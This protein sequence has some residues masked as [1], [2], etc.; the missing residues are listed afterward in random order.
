M[1]K[2]VS[3]PIDIEVATTTRPKPQRALRFRPLLSILCCIV[4]VQSLRL[5][6]FHNAFLQ[7][8]DTRARVISIHP[9]HR[10]ELQAICKSIR[11]PAGPPHSFSTAARTENDRFVPGT[12]PVL[13]RNA[14]IWTGSGNGTEIVHGDVLLDRGLVVAIGDIPPSLLDRVRQSSGS[15]LRVEDVGGAWVTPGLVDLHSHLG[16]GSAPYLSG[17]SCH[18]LLLSIVH[19]CWRPMNN[20]SLRCIRH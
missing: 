5:L 14:T 9:H 11:T 10:S 1:A 12:P 4:V 16:V 19:L 6:T 20:F 13:L 3:V 7:G 8:T 15:G 17:K 18:F 2:V